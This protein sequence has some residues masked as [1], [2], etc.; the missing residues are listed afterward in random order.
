MMYIC[1]QQ[2]S[3]RMRKLWG[4]KQR[5]KKSPG[6]RRKCIEDSRLS[7][8]H[9]FRLTFAGLLHSDESHHHPQQLLQTWEESGGSTG[10]TAGKRLNA[11][12]CLGEWDKSKRVQCRG[13]ESSFAKGKLEMLQR[14][15]S[16]ELADEGRRVLRLGFLLP[17]SL[18]LLAQIHTVG[19][20]TEAV[21]YTSCLASRGVL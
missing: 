19:L 10:S 16:T 3:K 11:D 5:G 21:T 15:Y 1:L 17:R 8:Q 12:K 20:C 18:F 7:V 4:R 2:S 9:C 14:K 6:S 13:F